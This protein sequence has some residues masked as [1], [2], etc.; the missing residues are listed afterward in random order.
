MNGVS[1]TRAI[2]FD[3]GGVCLTNGWDS[4]SRQRAA[5]H[6]SFDFEES[7]KYHD[8]AFEDFELGRIT[9]LDYLEKVYFFRK[10]KFSQEELIEFMKNQSRP[11]N[12]T[13]NILHELK[14]Q[15][16]YHLATINNESFVLNN[17]RIERYKLFRYF[18]NF[19]SSSFLHI[20]KPDKEI[21]NT[22]LHVLHRQPEEC[23]YIDDR[24]ENINSAKEVGLNCIHLQKVENLRKALKEHK[25]ELKNEKI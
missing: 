5:E 10:R 20:R 2:F 18:D 4:D 25:I 7:E 3:V 22:A 14:Q 15:G 8:T 11:K 17:F 1:D 24:L 23:L 6:F 13:L 12:S 16:K 21:F 19:F 9:L